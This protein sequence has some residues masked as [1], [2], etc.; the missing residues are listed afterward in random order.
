MAR[1]LEHIARQDDIHLWRI[2]KDLNWA[3]IVIEGPPDSFYHGTSV[4]IGMDEVGSM[5]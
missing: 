5:P 4:L 1:E 2:G 3:E